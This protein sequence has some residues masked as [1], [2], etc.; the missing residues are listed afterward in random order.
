M[1][2]SPVRV[3]VVDDEPEVRLLFRYLLAADGRFRVVGEAADG[4]EA[5]AV[6]ERERPDAV[7]LDLMM[8]GT[9]GLSALPRLRALAPVV[10]VS[11]YD[12]REAAVARG[13]RAFLA[14]DRAPASLCQVI[15]DLTQAEAGGGR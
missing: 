12:E 4:A 1:G 7:V 14:K 9:S 2:D 6:A 11:A 8:P 5:V 13:A 10:V 3:V 15:I